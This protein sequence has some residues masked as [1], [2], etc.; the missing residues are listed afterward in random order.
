M[1]PSNQLRSPALSLAQHPESNGEVILRR[2]PGDRHTIAPPLLQ[3]RAIGRDP[4]NYSFP[5]ASKGRPH[6]AQ[7]DWVKASQ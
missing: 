3:H 7:G 6:M 5:L 1:V 2:R 4:S